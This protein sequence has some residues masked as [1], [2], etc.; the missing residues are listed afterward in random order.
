MG[1]EIKRVPT[2]CANRRNN[3]FRCATG[4][5][6]VAHTPDKDGSDCINCPNFEYEY[7]RKVNKELSAEEDSKKG[8]AMGTVV[9]VCF[10]ILVAAGIFAAT[11]LIKSLAG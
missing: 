1:G 9:L 2:V 4:E 6:G 8:A 5:N 11:L 7:S 10:A 3:N